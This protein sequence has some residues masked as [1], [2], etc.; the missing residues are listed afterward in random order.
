MLKQPLV[1][2]HGL[3]FVDRPL[4]VYGSTVEKLVELILGMVHQSPEVSETR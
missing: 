1:V 3:I 4:V 2:E